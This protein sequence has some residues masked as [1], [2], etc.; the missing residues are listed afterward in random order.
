M[1]NAINS[2]A[3]RACCT[4]ARGLFVIIFLTLTGCALPSA[5]V[6]PVVFDFGPGALHLPAANHAASQPPLAL[7]EV[8]AS[9]A[10][11]GSAVLYRLAYSDAQQLRPYALARWSMPPAQLVRQRL[12]ELLGQNRAVLSPGDGGP[13]SAATSATA[14]TPQALA[15]PRTLRVEL[16]EFSQLFETP[17][18]STGLLRLRATLVQPGP[19]GERLVAQRSV[20]VQRPAPTADASGGVRALTA[21]TDAAVQEI[22]AWLLGLAP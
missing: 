9:P 11:E 16:E 22:D 1:K 7:A 20:I 17:E 21:A 12:R 14:P 8:E 5:S 3:A 15:S 4:V 18:R 13:I 2:V 10:L 6:R 19:S